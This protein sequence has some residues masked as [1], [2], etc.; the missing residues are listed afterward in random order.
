MPIGHTQ[1]VIST[2]AAQ[3]F[4]V[5]GA[6]PNFTKL[7]GVHSHRHTLATTI[8][9]FYMAIIFPFHN[10][11]LEYE[12][13]ARAS[14]MHMVDRRNNLILQLKFDFTIRRTEY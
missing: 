13:D 3:L 1:Q 6:T 7:P 14:R 12:R 10:F 5:P 9:R 4:P 8:R 11:V 2:K